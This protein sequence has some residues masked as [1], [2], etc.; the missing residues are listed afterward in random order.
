MNMMQKRLLRH[1]V[2]HSLLQ[3]PKMRANKMKQF[4]MYKKIFLTA[5]LLLVATITQA[6][7]KK[8]DVLIK[9]GTLLTISQGTM[10]NTD[11]LVKDGK[12]SKIGKNLKA[13]NGVEVVDAS[14]QFVLPGIIDAHS[15]IAGSS[16]NEGT[17]QVTA[18]VTME[19]VVNPL[20]ISIYRAVAGGV[21]AINLMHG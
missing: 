3:Q 5:L 19:D 7:V 14:G 2:S 12:I 13:P 21:T 1:S 17:S 4:N 15:H 6:Q 10:E 11:L 18:E 9:N 20:D 16:I 8:G